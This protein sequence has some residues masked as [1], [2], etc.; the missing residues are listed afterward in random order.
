MAE[1]EWAK[2]NPG[3]SQK[4]GLPSEYLT[5]VL[6][7]HALWLLPSTFSGADPK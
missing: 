4:P 1:Q 5:W 3:P 7:A 2:S 6:G